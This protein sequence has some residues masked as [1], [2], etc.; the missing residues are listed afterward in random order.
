[1]AINPLFSN[2]K[3]L[4]SSLSC[5]TV[6]MSRDS[7]KPPEKRRRTDDETEGKF[8]EM[9]D[10][11]MVFSQ[12][13]IQ[14]IDV[15]ASQAYTS[16]TKEEHPNSNGGTQPYLL[17]R[18][19]PTHPVSADFQQPVPHPSVSQTSRKSSSSLSLSRGSSSTAS[20][21]YPSSAS[22]NRSTD[23]GNVSSH[24]SMD[25]G[26]GDSRLQQQSTEKSDVKDTLYAKDGEIKILR[27]SLKRREAEL[28]KTRE[29]H[30][31]LI[32]QMATQKASL[33]ETFRTDTDRLQTQLQFRD[34]E[35]KELEEKCRLMEHRLQS[36][37]SGSPIK[38]SSPKS[39]S[40]VSRKVRPD[41][42]PNSKSSFPSRQSFMS[43]KRESS[44]P[45]PS[46]SAA[47]QE[48]VSQHVLSKGK[49]QPI[50]VRPGKPRSRRHVLNTSMTRGEVTGPCLVY[51]MFEHHPSVPQ[52][53]GDHGVIG[54]LHTP[55]TQLDLHNIQFDRDSTS[56]ILSPVRSKRLS[57]LQVS[58]QSAECADTCSVVPRDHYLMAV[59][60]LQ[61]LLKSQPQ[62]RDNT[63]L[64]TD[65][66]L[67]HSQELSG[68]VLILPLIND[69]LSHYLDILS[70]SPVSGSSSGTLNSSLGRGSASESSLESVTSSIGF[71][72]KDY[73]NSAN[74][75]ECLCLTSLRTLHKLVMFS[76][77]VR[78][79]LMDKTDWNHNRSDAS[80]DGYRASADSSASGETAMDTDVPVT[81]SSDNDTMSL[82]S[83]VTFRQ[84]QELNLL[85]K[86]VKLAHPQ[87]ES[88]SVCMVEEALNIIIL[89]ASIWKDDNHFR[90]HTALSRGA[91]LCC[92][93][94]K[95]G[96][97]QWGIITRAVTIL[98][99]LTRTQKVIQVLCT[100][101]EACPLLH[102]YLVS[103]KLSDDTAW[104]TQ[105]VIYQQTVTCLTNIASDPADASTILGNHCP[106]TTEAGR[107]L[108][109]CMLRL[110]QHYKGQ[111]PA[112]TLQSLRD[113]L[114]LLQLL[115]QRQ[116]QYLTDRDYE[117]QHDYVTL[118]CGLTSL[119]RQLPGNQETEL[120]ALTDLWDFN[121]DDS[122]LSPD[123]DQEDS[124]ES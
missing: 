100:K 3:H 55:A 90:L 121:Q 105:E 7:E 25:S 58:L 24:S 86:I 87:G 45:K 70:N 51:H 88:Y 77:A 110:Y 96:M 114:L 29:D 17:G 101:S 74:N 91:I 115:Q 123:S 6:N 23:G 32:D 11:E 60:G 120:N 37:Q 62:C 19:K 106:C 76:E 21:A 48:P 104:D 118:I 44:E 36:F 26:R 10:D 33:K 42:S 80:L 59:E 103:L 8:D 92:L 71:L 67:A 82:D 99:H 113:G 56:N 27:E 12:A 52:D 40:P 102:L 47:Q 4:Y 97:T 35:F 5:Q 63:V 39:R 22:S 79:S 16:K 1:M 31:H 119:F 73:Q 72:L 107:C 49:T 109:V 117:L 75:L 64:N 20:T 61:D 18:R 81:S 41:V 43:D 78:R 95:V 93:E 50:N 124:M 28:V 66:H 94:C 108:V 98:G 57:D 65:P 53:P 14:S 38:H 111:H 30:V 2:Y 69:Y 116:E 112:H 13:D 85:N 9:W 34:Q 84:L 68:A 83:R 15:M 54:L 89:L 122:E 46:T